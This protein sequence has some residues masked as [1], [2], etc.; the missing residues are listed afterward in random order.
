MISCLVMVID[1]C[2]I[3]YA[4]AAHPDLPRDVPVLAV[5]SFVCS[6]Y[7]LSRRAS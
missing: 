6:W 4:V 7:Y 5:I 1:V 3:V 2:V